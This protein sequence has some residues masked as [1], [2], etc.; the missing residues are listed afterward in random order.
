MEIT[1]TGHWPEAKSAL[2]AFIEGRQA[3]LFE[4]ASNI[5]GDHWRASGRRQDEGAKG[6]DR[7]QYMVSCRLG[8]AG[9]KLFWRRIWTVYDNKQGRWVQRSS[10]ISLGKGNTRHKMG[11]FRMAADWEREIIDSVE[12][13]LAG[14]RKESLWLVRLVQLMANHPAEVEARGNRKSGTADACVLSEP[15]PEEAARWSL[16]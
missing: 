2:Q 9:L 5:C 13:R 4:T 10:H 1:S 3:A 16:T 12:E 6:K 14:V 15:D 8:R 11:S 7:A